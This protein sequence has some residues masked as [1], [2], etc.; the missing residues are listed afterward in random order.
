MIVLFPSPLDWGIAMVGVFWILRGLFRG[1]VAE[2]T[3]L[4]G[5]VGGFILS[6]RLSPPVIS[7]LSKMDMPGWVCSILAFFLVFAATVILC[8]ILG[9][10]VRMILQ[11]ANLSVLDRVLGGLFGAF[12]LALLVFMIFA[13]A[14]AASPLL[15]SGWEG[16]SFF[17]SLAASNREV[18]GIFDSALR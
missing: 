13:V 11:K 10:S 12:K 15:P 1:F 8:K 18:I 3:S 2:F 6:I 7:L 5:W 9:G 16:R 14:H 17:M 4:V